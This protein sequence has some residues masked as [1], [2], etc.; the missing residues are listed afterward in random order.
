[1]PI[2]PLAPSVG[3]GLPRS[4]LTRAVQILINAISQFPPERRGWQPGDRFYLARHMGLI[5]VPAIDRHLPE[6]ISLAN[7]LKRF[8]KPHQ[9]NEFAGRTVRSIMSAIDLSE[10][11]LTPH[12]RKRM[13]KT[14]IGA[15]TERVSAFCAAQYRNACGCCSHSPDSA[16]TKGGDPR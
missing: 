13:A 11:R 8:V 7:A 2:T 12:G 14:F 6:R 4:R 3:T 16:R 9:L 15:L 10:N 5:T 1:M